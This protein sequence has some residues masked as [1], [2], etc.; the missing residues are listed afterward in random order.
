MTD[1]S[2][3]LPPV[4]EAWLPREHSLYRPRH[5]KRQVTALV[6]AAA[7]FAAPALGWVFG[8]RP[9]EIENRELAS[10]PSLADGWGFF[11]GMPQWA[12]DHLVFREGA[13]EAADGISHGLFGEPAPMGQGE[14]TGPIPGVP[15][16]PQ[17]QS[18][19]GDA[20]DGQQQNAGYTEVIEGS[21][22]WLYY[23][24][25]VKGKCFPERP[26]S[27]TFERLD[28]IRHAVEASGRRFVLTIAPDKTTMVPQHLPD[29]Y[30]GKECSTET[31]ERFWKLAAQL[32]SF[33]D[34]R[35]SLEDAEQQL[36]HPPYFA[37]D[38][39]W[40]DDGA[41]MLTRDVAEALQPGVTDTWRSRGVG[42]STSNGDLASM[43]GRSEPKTSVRYELMPDGST[44]RTQD[45]LR[46]F[47]G[48]V[49]YDADAG[50]DIEGTIGAP[51]ALIGDS[52]TFASSRYLP[53][54]FA[55]LTLL[56]YPQLGDHKKATIDTFIRSEI[57]VVQTVERSVAEG[58]LPLIDEGFIEL[59][60]RRLAA[61]PIR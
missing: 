10:F 60:E 17:G 20:Q 15:D 46:K 3:K 18:G 19:D 54:A 23:G 29:S 33:L 6:C 28:R 40:T 48:P 22:G 52:F 49:R 39:H 27:E 5:G 43:L 53:A 41:V 1:T 37:N 7:F 32:R 26:L 21:D 34:V 16:G 42:W 35:P 56:S 11:T 59:M 4:H 12:T 31:T 9:S 24:D 57:V 25:D 55:D 45:T 50:R 13:I 30:A 44:D 38:T 2:R 51:T 36:G 58:D 14:G 8:G 61:N 47:D